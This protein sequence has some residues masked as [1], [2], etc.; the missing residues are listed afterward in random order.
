MTRSAPTCIKVLFLT[1]FLSKPQVRSCLKVPRAGEDDRN[2]S[3]LNRFTPR[4]RL[5]GDFVHE[6]RGKK[7]KLEASRETTVMLGSDV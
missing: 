3:P 1:P 5:V 7:F 2:I 6:L 4:K